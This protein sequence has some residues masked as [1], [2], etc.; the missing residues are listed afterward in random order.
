[1]KKV[2]FTMKLL[3]GAAEEYKRRHDLLW[4]ELVQVLRQTGI[5]NYSIFLE[6]KSNTLFAV[7]HIEDP[8]TARDLPAQEIMKRWWQYMKDLMEV[9]PD[10]APVTIQLKEVFYL[11]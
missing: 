3:P 6:E 1:M 10:G 7:Y 2:A 8:A 11:P 5:R 4:P 9:H